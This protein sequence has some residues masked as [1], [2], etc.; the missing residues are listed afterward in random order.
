M[1]RIFWSAAEQDAVQEELVRLFRENPAM[2]DEVAIATAQ[3]VLPME[4]RRKVHTSYVYRAKLRLAAARKEAK[5]APPAPTPAPPI[6][7]AQPKPQPDLLRAILDPIIDALVDRIVERLEL[8]AADFGPGAQH[9]YALRLKHDPTPPPN[10]R[11]A[12]TG[13]LVVGLLNQQA[14]TIISHF[15]HLEITCLTAEEAL[16]REQLRRSHTVLMTKFISH[17]VQDKYRKVPNLHLCNGGVS[18]LSAILKSVP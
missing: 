14:A 7:P 16:K 13:V 8:K 1:S 17:S 9:A 11:A 6:E 12:R 4:R 5:T 15:P 18:E 3:V 10:D 2:R